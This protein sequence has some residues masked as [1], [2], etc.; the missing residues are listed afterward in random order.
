MRWLQNIHFQLF[1]HLSD[2]KGLNLNTFNASI[3][4]MT[5]CMQ[6]SR[7]VLGLS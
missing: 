3:L 5:M 6:I 7:P 2:G 4:T 1:E